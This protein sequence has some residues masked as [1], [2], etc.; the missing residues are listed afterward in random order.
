MKERSSLYGEGL[1][2]AGRIAPT[3]SAKLLAL[4]SNSRVQPALAP[5]LIVPEVALS[6]TE[7]LVTPF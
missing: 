5:N 7:M 6:E 2:A 3:T 4:Y 1:R